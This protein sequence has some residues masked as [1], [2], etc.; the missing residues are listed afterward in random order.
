[1]R[2]TIAILLFVTSTLLA[3]NSV[4]QSAP[5]CG[6]ATVKFDVKTEKARSKTPTPGPGKALVFFFQDDLNFNSR[7]RPTTR[8]GIDGTWAGATHADSY[9][10][11]YV[12]PGEHHICAS[13]QPMIM[14]SS[15]RMRTTA[16]APLIAEDGKSYYFR[17][18]DVTKTENPF[19]KGDIVSEAEVV[20]EP[21]NSDEA[22][23]LVNTFSISSSHPKK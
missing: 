9:F 21:L 4:A 6:P 20:L 19:G 2:L 10:F 17:A 15:P 8:F 12:D 16:A 11:T 13:W 23:V 14:P 1:M 18:R 3:S 7:P 5:G 22:Q